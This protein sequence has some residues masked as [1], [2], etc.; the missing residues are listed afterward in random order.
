[1]EKLQIKELSKRKRHNHI[2]INKSNAK[3]YN[4]VLYTL[5]MP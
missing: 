1:M 3:F 5:V 2:L 4:A